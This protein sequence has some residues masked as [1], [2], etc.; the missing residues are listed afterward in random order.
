MQLQSEYL[1]GCAKMRQDK[2]QANMFSIVR[3]VCVTY[4]YQF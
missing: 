2:P 1:A 4:I 3:L